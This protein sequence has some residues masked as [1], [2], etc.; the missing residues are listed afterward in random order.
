M[1]FFIHTTGCKANQWDS[2]IITNR[3]SVKGHTPCALRNAD[4]VVVNACTLTGN[5]ERD[6]RRFINHCRTVNSK[7]RVIIAGCHAQVYPEKT[8]GADLMLG[9]S[10]KFFID[11]YIEKSGVIKGITD[12]SCMEIALIKKMPDRRTRFFLKI[13]DGCDKFCSYCIVPFA[14]GR[15]RSRDADEIIQVMQTIKARG[16]HEVVLT[17]IEISDY[18]D[19]AKNLDL[20]GLMRLIED[21]DTPE[22]IRLSSVDPLYI[23]DEFIDILGTSKKFTKS[24]HVPIQSGSDKILKKMGRGYSSSYL[25]DIIKKLLMSIENIGIGVDVMV[26]FPY[27]DENSFMDTYNLL[28]SLDIY[29]FHVFPFSPRENTRASDMD[30]QVSEAVKKD[31]VK[32]LR[33][34]DKKKRLIF[35][36]RFIGGNATIVPEGK[37]YKNCYMR[38]YTENYIPVYIPYE[39]TLENRLIEVKIKGLKDSILEGEK[40]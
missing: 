21:S 3:L 4:F 37:I 12:D 24:I 13:Q 11:Q 29:Y 35:Y 8:Y 22:R 36:E 7:A 39:K 25:S 26:G 30:N 20:K 9:N 34:L 27:E 18:K 2:Y 31:R 5:A 38:G 33:L 14:R 17:G 16:I 1:R 23:N 19:D 28:E 6:I 15:P 32:R 40:I 10:E